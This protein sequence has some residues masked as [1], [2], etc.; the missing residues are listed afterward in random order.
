MLLCCDLGGAPRSPG[1]AV[2]GGECAPKCAIRWGS[3]SCTQGGGGSWGWS[4]GVTGNP[5]APQA[6]AG[7]VTW[8]CHDG[9]WDWDLPHSPCPFRT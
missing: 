4:H 5:R 6:K 7:E 2:H 8:G 9:D 3:L 1:R